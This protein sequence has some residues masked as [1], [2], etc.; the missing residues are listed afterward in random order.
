MDYLIPEPWDIQWSRP[1]YNYEKHHQFFWSKIKDKAEGRILDIGCGSASCWKDTNV[2]L[3]GIDF[4]KKGIEQALI[5]YPNGQYLIGS[6]P[7]DYYDGM[8]F[9]T[10]VLSGIINYYYNL[11]PL[12]E[13]VKN[14]S[15]TGC[16]VL[17][18]I[19]VIQDFPGRKWDL[20]RIKTEFSV[21][22]EINAEFTEKIGWF[23][24]I[25]VS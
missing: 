23:V 2:E 13:M 5:N 19:N 15:K 25:V 8:E 10:I 1:Y 9:D 12:L 21:L 22:G 3:Y 11:K 20:E 17:I 4:S 16:L 7:T 14:A 18:T 6:F 24:E